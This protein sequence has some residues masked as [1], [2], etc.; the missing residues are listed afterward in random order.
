MKALILALLAAAAQAQTQPTT[1]DWWR[2]AVLYEIYPRSFGD[3]NGDGIGDLNGITQHLD[4]LQSLGVDGV[5]IAPFFPSPQVDFGYDITDNE[6]IDP[7]FG[8]MADFDRLLAEAKKRNIKV[9]LDLVVNH[10]SD[11]HPWFIESRSSRTN[12]KAD[13]YVWLDRKDAPNNWTSIFGGSAWQYDPQRGQVYYHQFYK[14]QPDLNWR[15]PEVR[16]AM[17]DVMRFWMRKGVAGFR[18]DAVPHMFEDPQLRDEPVTKA[19]KNAYGDLFVNRQYTSNLTELHEVL[20]EMRKVVEEFPGAVLVGETYL[21]DI[22]ELAKMYGAHH[23]ELQLPM[24]TQYGFGDLTATRLRAKLVDAETKLNGDTPLFV[25]DNHDNVRSWT[26]FAD[27]KNDAAIA[28]LIATALLTPKAAALLYYGEEIGM[29]NDDPKRKEDVR[30]II[31]IKGWPQ[32]KG[33]DGERKPMQW[34]AD[35][36][37]GFGPSPQPWLPVAPDYKTLNVAAEA[38]DPSS[39]LAFYKALIALRRD[40]AAL[41]E[42][43]FELVD[44]ADPNILAFLRKAKDGSTALILVNCSNAPHAP[45]SLTAKHGKVLIGSFAQPGAVLDLSHLTL[46]PY[47]SAVLTVVD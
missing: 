10:T 44:A 4:Y 32:D 5:W 26:R 14:E 30:D 1:T 16:K 40:N 6:G 27:G 41:R 46:P 23:D 47:G 13:W 28:R 20:R 24:D 31:G 9:L 18:L 7:Q 8:T 17:Y 22:K 19:G 39:L 37:A 34:N 15:N 38:K 33:R 42:G 36:N 35:T 25:W 21:P 3:T 45:A 29:R 12:P 11:R 2:T 43:S